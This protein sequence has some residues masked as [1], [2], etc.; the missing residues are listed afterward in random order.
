MDNHSNES[1]EILTVS[2]VAEYLKISEVTTYKLVQKGVIPS[3]KIGRSWRVKYEDL[4]AFIEKKKG[5]RYL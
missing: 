1:H 2:E 4:L 3:F 5:E